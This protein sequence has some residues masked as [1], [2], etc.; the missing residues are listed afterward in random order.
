VAR[1]TGWDDGPGRESEGGRVVLLLILGLALLTGGAYLAA[2]VAAGDELPVGTRVAGVD[3]GGHSPASAVDVL[4][5]G[6]AGRARTPFTVTVNGH[7]QQV[8]PSEVGLGVDYAA[9]VRSAAAGR[10]WRPS[11]LWAHY[12]A[13]SDVAPVVTLDQARLARLLK[14]L[15]DA[16]G[17]RPT[18]GSVVFH[19]RTFVVTP[20]R[21]GL[22]V[23]PEAAGTAFWDAYLSDDPTVQLPLAATQP[24]VGA[25]AVQRFVRTFANPAV[26][27]PVRMRL[28][29]ST[30]QLAPDDYAR[31][32]RARREGHRLVPTVRAAA[33]AR[34]TNRRLPGDSVDRP[35]DA[36]IALLGGVPRLVRARPGLAFKA[37]D[38]ASALL[39]AIRSPDRSARVRPTPA[40]AR[41]T[42]ADAL[43]LAIRRQVSS[44]AVHLPRGDAGRLLAAA[45]RVDGTVLRPGRAFSLRGLLGPETPAGHAGDALATAVFNA[46]WLGGFR[47]TAHAA[48]ATYHDR[49]PVGRDASLRDGQDVAFTDSSRYGVLVSV[50]TDAPTAGHGGT[51]TVALWSTPQWSISS[52]HG[53]RTDV[54]SAGQVV[55][56]GK[57]CRSRAGRVGFTVTVTRSFSPVGSA[58]IDH[59]SSYTVR[60]APRQAVVC[61]RR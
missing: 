60:Y 41:F 42:D 22:V 55:R 26:A 50:T 49:A 2:Y 20:P 10:S 8:R 56:Q 40:Q 30:L 21:V 9:S 11:R 16:D 4:R 31:L 1:A 18:A 36:T 61:R 28:G 27:A 24:A 48:A 37:P 44:Y 58:T 14:R 6:L 53:A 39:R 19:R 35:R 34:L 46:A 54:V 32:L 25:R 5:H 3:I 23:D 13:G 38:V 7:T 59:R 52:A 29:H 15:D 33:L 57:Q 45:H 12:T 47:V 51:L 43:A 17:R